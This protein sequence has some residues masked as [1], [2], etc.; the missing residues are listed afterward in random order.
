MKSLEKLYCE[1]HRCTLEE[2]PQCAFRECLHRHAR[3]FAPLLGG[4][5]A[6]YF[7]ADRGLIIA[8]GRAAK[9]SEVRAAIDDYFNE[10]D[11]RRWLRARLNMR[12]ST[13][14]LV[15]LANR[16]LPGSGS[17]SPVSEKA[18]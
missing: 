4:F 3:P 11:N 14:R 10:P 6:K 9:R 18:K 12:L 2:F 17:R 16:Y 8:A 13:R 7:A 1:E 5:R 15:G